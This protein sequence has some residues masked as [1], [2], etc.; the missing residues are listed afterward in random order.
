MGGSSSDGNLVTA[1]KFNSFYFWPNPT[2]LKVIGI[3]E[4]SS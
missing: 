4:Q 2:T 1:G 3:D